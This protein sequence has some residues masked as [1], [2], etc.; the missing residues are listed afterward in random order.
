MPRIL[1]YGGCGALGSAVVTSFKSNGWE[2]VSVDFSA[3]PHAT[4]SVVIAGSGKDDISR[5]IEE[6]QKKSITA[7][8]TL[9]C[10]AGGWNGGSIEKDDI[11]A[12][13]EKMWQF[14]VQSA[15]AASHVASKTLTEGGMLVLTGAY[16]AINS[17]PG[18]IAYGITKSAT[19][20]LIKSLAAPNSG[21]PAKA[22]VV[23][24]L[25]VTLDTPTNR[26][27]MP[28]AKFDEWTPL[29]VVSSRLFEWASSPDSR[30]SSGSLI[31][32]KTS[33][34]HTDFESVSVSY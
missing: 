27:A 22:T 16:A 20:H 19:H 30:P 17:T 1:V 34:N 7:I 32:L 2:T 6:L 21:L 23:G 3:S 18:M 8:D 33:N 4:H 12:T 31:A 13:T 24:I 15:V 26:A 5:V 10:V 25:P 14:N 29:D 11:F 9:V 28:K